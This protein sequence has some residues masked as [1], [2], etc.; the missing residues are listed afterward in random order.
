MCTLL[1]LEV[2]PAVIIAMTAA[3]AMVALRVMSVSQAQPVALSTLVVVAGMIPLSTAIQTSGAADLISDALVRAVGGG[4]PL[5]LQLGIVVVVLVLGQFIS[6]LATVLVVA[7]IAL[8]IAATA[9][10]SPLPF[11]MGMAVAGAAA[12]L[13][14]VATPANLM[15]MEP[16]ALRFGDYWKIGSPLLLLFGAV[17]TFLVPVIWR[18]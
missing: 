2:A 5:L 14:P 18:Y 8:S 1:T 11:L 17:A 9:D 13:T 6:N 12:F 10:V 16:G 4:N 7:P 15:I 3:G